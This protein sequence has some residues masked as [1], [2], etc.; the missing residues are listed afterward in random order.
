MKQGCET[1]F[2]N[3]SRRHDEESFGRR[4]QGKV[5]LISREL[6]RAEA[7]RRLDFGCVAD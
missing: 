4:T 3:Y 2:D 5:A 6:V 7:A 1:L